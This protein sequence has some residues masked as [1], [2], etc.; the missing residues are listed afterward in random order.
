MHTRREPAADAVLGF[1]L[2]ANPRS[3]RGELSAGVPIRRDKG[4]AVAVVILLAPPSLAPR[5]VGRPPGFV[6]D[7][8]DRVKPVR[9]VALLDTL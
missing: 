6:L 7:R 5:A 8:A 4:K 2:A 1:G 3:A 9:W